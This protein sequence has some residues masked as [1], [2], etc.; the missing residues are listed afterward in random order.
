MEVNQKMLFHHHAVENLTIVAILGG[1]LARKVFNC[2][3]QLLKCANNSIRVETLFL[4]STVIW[5]TSYVHIAKGPVINYGRGA[6][7]EKR[8]AA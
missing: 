1:F 5:R 3:N 2:T 8:G 6:V 4:V 7:G